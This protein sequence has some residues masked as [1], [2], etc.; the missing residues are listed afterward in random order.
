MSHTDTAL[1]TAHTEV[2]AEL[3]RTDTK[4]SLL[5]AFTGAALAGVWTIATNTH[6]PMAALAVG[7][8]GVAVLLVVVGVLLRAVRPNLGGG[9]GFPLWATLTPD[10]IEAHLSENGKAADI[11]GLSRIAVAKFTRLQRAI[12]L[13]YAAG[14]LL[15]VAALIVLGGAA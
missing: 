12:D 7:G 2:K 8:L 4:A 13:T 10:G 11:A 5:L 3:A 6:L 14:A 9:A 1:A 15:V